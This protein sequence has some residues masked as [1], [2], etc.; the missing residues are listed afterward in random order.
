MA[1]HIK[2]S[3][4]RRIPKQLPQTIYEL[5]AAGG[6][7]TLV[8]AAAEAAARQER[9]FWLDV[10]EGINQDDLDEQDQMFCGLYIQDLRRRLGISQSK[11]M[12]R[13]QTRLRVRRFRERRARPIQ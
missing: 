6:P 4:S 5:V 9:K 11:E 1:R 7:E 8:K 13:E 12:I 3:R 2:R 10:L